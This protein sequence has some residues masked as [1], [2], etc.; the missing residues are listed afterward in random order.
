MTGNGDCFV[1]AGRYILDHPNT[2]LI[3]GVVEGQGKLE[4]VLFTHA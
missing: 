2:T 4:G 3:H 1:V